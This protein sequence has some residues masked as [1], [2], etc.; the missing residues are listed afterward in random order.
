MTT[1]E[2]QIIEENCLNTMIVDYLE[3]II[4]KVR[5]GKIDMVRYHFHNKTLSSCS[6]RVI[7]VEYRFMPNNDVSVS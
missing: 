1:K 4:K 3:S 6:D 5:E 2:P 7:E